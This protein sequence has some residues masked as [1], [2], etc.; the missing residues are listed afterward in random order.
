MSKKQIANV[1]NETEFV[2]VEGYTTDLTTLFPKIS[3]VINPLI[4]HAREGL[5]QIEKMLYSSSSFVEVLKSLVP[6]ETLQA[7]LTDE[8]KQKIASGALKIMARKDGSLMA[9]LVNPKTNKIV[10][11]ISLETVKLTPDLGRAITSF[12]SQMQ[13]AQ[14]AEQIQYVQVAIEEVR[15]GQENDRLAT[16]YSCQQKFLQ[17]MTIQNPQLRTAAL[18]RIAFDAEDSRNLLMQSQNTNATFIRNQP[19]SIIGKMIHGERPKK[20]NDRLN[21]LRDGLNAINM[22]SLVEAMAYTELGEQQAANQSLMFYSD[23][24]DKTFLSHKGFVS[25]LDSIDPSPKE[26]WSK[27]LPL[28]MKKI[29]NLPE[30]INNE[31]I[32]MLGE[33]TSEKEE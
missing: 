26:Y 29:Q 23:F 31:E 10:S 30:Y 17:A 33:T 27:A 32:G 1:N 6:S 11:T 3:S 4:D 5:F 16:A 22:V 15:Q 8:Q 21:E 14:I 2:Q 24:L 7:I 12:S 25:R 19:E 13:M 18:M 28:I 20:I 9:N